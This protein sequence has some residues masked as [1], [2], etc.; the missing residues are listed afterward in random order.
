M[1]E[2]VVVHGRGRGV[3]DDGYPLPVEPDREVVVKSVQPLSLEEIMATGRD[4]THD[5]LRVWAPS[6]SGIRPDDEVT[7]RG[8]RYTVEKTSWDWAQHRRPALARHRPSEVFDCVRGV[9]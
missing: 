5:V 4:G 9:G 2:V 1:A 3:D 8:L 7:V 6:G